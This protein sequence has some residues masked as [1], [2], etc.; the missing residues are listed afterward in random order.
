MLVESKTR[1]FSD[2]EIEYL[3]SLWD[4]NDGQEFIL[5]DREY[6]SNL[7]SNVPNSITTKFY[8]W[9]ELNL[10]KTIFHKHSYLVLHKFKEGDYFNLHKDDGYRNKGKRLY[11]AGFN[12]NTN[13]SG[14]EFCAILD[15]E[16][17]TIGE[18]PGAPYLFSSD[19]LHK[20]NKVKKGVRWS[21]LMF[22]YED[23]FLEKSR[24]PKKKSSK[25]KPKK[26]VRSKKKGL[27]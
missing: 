24:L 11:A 21:I 14:G 18:I 22:L 3:L 1:L 2:K 26:K 23:D 10:G 4:E 13:Y 12:L 16:E 25:S 6:S 20:I 15:N 27:I 17:I 7:L 19:I 9:L 8:D 5:S